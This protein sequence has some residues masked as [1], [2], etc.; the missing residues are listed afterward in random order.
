MRARMSIRRLRGR[1]A[2]MMSLRN[3]IRHKRS[4]STSTLMTSMATWSVSAQ[5]SSSATSCSRTKI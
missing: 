4:R 3:R 2:S 5:N 1:N